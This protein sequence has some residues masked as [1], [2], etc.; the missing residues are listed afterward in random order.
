MVL[1][2]GQILCITFLLNDLIEFA[3]STT[4]SDSDHCLHPGLLQFYHVMGQVLKCLTNVL[5]VYRLESMIVKVPQLRLFNLQLQHRPQHDVGAGRRLFGIENATIPNPF[6]RCYIPT[7]CKCV[8]PSNLD[9][10]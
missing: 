1:W 3:C 4:C 10:K 9:I 2:S 6:S 8:K 5:F 7:S